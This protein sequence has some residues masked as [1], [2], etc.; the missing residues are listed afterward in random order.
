MKIT[1][2]DTMFEELGEKKC[3]LNIDDVLVEASSGAFCLLTSWLGFPTI[4]DCL[5]KQAQ[6]LSIS[7]SKLGS[8]FSNF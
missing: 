6:D 2:Q 8:E 4:P 3:F 1:Q 7:D 5:S